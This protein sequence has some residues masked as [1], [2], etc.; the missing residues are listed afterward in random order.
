MK[1]KLFTGLFLL[2]LLTC[3]FAFTPQKKSKKQVAWAYIHLVCTNKWQEASMF[4]RKIAEEEKDKQY[5]EA[6]E[7]LAKA[8]SSSFDYYDFYQRFILPQTVIFSEKFLVKKTFKTEEIALGKLLFYDP[9]LSANEK[10]TC[11][12]CHRAEK[13][14]CDQR[15]TSKGVDFS[16][17]LKKNSPSLINVAYENAFFHEANAKNISEVIESVIKNPQEFNNDY[18]TILA[19]LNQS[20]EYKKLLFGAYGKQNWTKKLLNHALEAFVNNLTSLES[21]FDQSINDPKK[22]VAEN[23]KQGY[24]TFMGI[25][26]CG[27]CHRP[28]TF[29]GS[30]NPFS[31]HYLTVNYQEIQLKVPSLRHSNQSFPYMHDGR[32]IKLADVYTDE[33]H[34]AFVPKSLTKEQIEVI[35]TFLLY[36]CDNIVSDTQIPNK[37]PELTHKHK[38]NPGGLY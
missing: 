15:I 31:N 21:T 36:I 11:S 38:R 10:R 4:F 32:A 5:T 3:I 30:D 24:N 20:E 23:L 17:N 22:Q 25:G 19:K 27:T 7:L 28:P 9:V 14:F 35:N 6:A 34:T 37:L 12:S 16:V 29:G 26:E 13:A 1:T 2:I 8:N 18:G 33:Y